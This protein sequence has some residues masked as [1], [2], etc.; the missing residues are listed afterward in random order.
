MKECFLGI[1]MGTTGLRGMLVDCKGNV[2]TSYSVSIEDSIIESSDGTLS[3][4]NP[5]IWERA[6]N[7]VLSKIFNT[8]NRKE[9]SIVALTVDSTSGT[10]LPIDKNYKPLSNAFMHNDMRAKKEAEFINKYSKI[11]AKPSFAISKILWI[12]NNWPDIFE[13]TYKFL[14]AADYLVGLL[15]GVFDKSDFSNSVKTGYDLKSMK[16]PEDIEK[17]LGIPINKLPDVVKTG[18]VIGELKKDIRDRYNLCDEI[19]VVA[20]ATDSTTGFYSSGAKEVGDWNTTLGTVLGL[21]GISADF[22]KDPD[23]VLY[24]HRHP[25]GY[26]L[27]GGASNSGAEVLRVFF[28][29]RVKDYDEELF[30][31]PPTG[32]IIYPLARKGE[33][34][35]FFN[36]DAR[37]FIKLNYCEPSYLFKAIL[38]GLCY[39]ERLIYEKIES[40]GYKV[41]DTIFSMGGGAYSKPWLHL[42]ATI[43]N[44]IVV[45]ARVVETAFGSAVIAASGSF[46]DSI[47]DAINNMVSIESYFKPNKE[48]LETYEKLYNGFIKELKNRGFI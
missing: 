30:K 23:G 24:T 1:D 13:K 19:K 34:L 9:W 28:H 3:E 38:E 7:D 31:I 12:K 41:N 16:W 29:D 36:M 37:G 42:R 5:A 26:W 35:P 27:P 21:R 32:G 33:K 17:K 8:Y 15:S 4:E 47:T 40:L 2:I 18:E 44:R 11:Q 46:F 48:E 10:I 6:L 14:H 39:L 25:E 45:R 22:I 20:G 43:L